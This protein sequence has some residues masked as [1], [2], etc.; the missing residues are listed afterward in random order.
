M[1]IKL[2]LSYLARVDG[3]CSLWRTQAH[4]DG[5]NLSPRQQCEHTLTNMGVEIKEDA[6]KQEDNQQLKF[7]E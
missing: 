5:A 4:I 1:H 3:K 2:E 6:G 7:G